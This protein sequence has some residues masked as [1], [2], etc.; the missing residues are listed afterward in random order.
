MPHGEKVR[1]RPQKRIAGEQQREQQAGGTPR[2]E[3]EN[4]EQRR[5]QQR[6]RLSQRERAIPGEGGQRA[7]YGREHRPQPGL[8]QRRPKET[9]EREEQGKGE[10]R[11]R[12]DEKHMFPSLYIHYSITAGGKANA[13][14]GRREGRHACLGREERARAV[15]AGGGYGKTAP[16]FREGGASIRDGAAVIKGPRRR[17][18]CWPASIRR[19]S[20]GS[21]SARGG[22]RPPAARGSPA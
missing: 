11:C 14:S 5:Q 7:A 8:R 13:I 12:G 22:S 4:D 20:G 18:R 2:T 15:P 6:Q 21:R 19:R 17:R 16:T 1:R 9:G 10:N 3:K